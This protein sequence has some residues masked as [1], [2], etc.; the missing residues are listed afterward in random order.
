MIRSISVIAILFYLILGYIGIN[1]YQE[2]EAGFLSDLK[3]TAKEMEKSSEESADMAECAEKN[4]EKTQFYSKQGK[5]YIPNP[6]CDPNTQY[7][8]DKLN[9]QNGINEYA[10]SAN[11]VVGADFDAEEND[12]EDDDDEDKKDNKKKK[13]DKND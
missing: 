2:A 7:K 10:D 9:Q 3:K 5:I 4:L 13:K 1:N 11:F 8:Y 6:D 12:E